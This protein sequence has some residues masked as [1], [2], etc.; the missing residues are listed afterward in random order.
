GIG[1]L[2][3]KS[4]EVATLSLEAPWPDDIIEVKDAY[5]VVKLRD[6]KKVEEKQ[7]SKDKDAYLKQLSSLKGSALVQGWLTAMKGKVPIE[8]NEELFGQYQ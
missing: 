2:G 7:Y 4:A 1:S 3:E 5:I 8:I 6:V